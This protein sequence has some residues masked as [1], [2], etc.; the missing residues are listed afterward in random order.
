MIAYVHSD[1]LLLVLAASYSSK[2]LFVSNNSDWPLLKSNLVLNDLCAL[3]TPVS[4]DQ[5]TNYVGYNMLV[6][7]NFS[8]V[9][10]LLLFQKRAVAIL[11]E[12][13]EPIRQQSAVLLKLKVYRFE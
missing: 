11:M 6:T 2:G 3:A 8:L 12:I 9:D 1:P 7:D 5:I 4:I 10:E 13:K